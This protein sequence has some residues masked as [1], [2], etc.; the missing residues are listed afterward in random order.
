MMI[1]Q[2]GAVE[3]L[4]KFLAEWGFEAKGRVMLVKTLS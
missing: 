3:L 4:F 1:R 2:L